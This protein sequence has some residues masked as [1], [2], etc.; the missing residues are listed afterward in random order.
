MLKMIV[1][2][3]G[4]VIN[5]VGPLTCNNH[6]DQAMEISSRAVNDDGMRDAWHDD[7]RI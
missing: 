1:C 2:C 3:F 4:D 7:D 5:E 6:S